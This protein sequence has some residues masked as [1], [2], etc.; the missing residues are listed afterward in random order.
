[1]ELWADLVANRNAVQ[2]ALGYLSE[3]APIVLL[4]TDR[5]GRILSANR[6]AEHLLGP[7]KGKFFVRDVVVDFTGNLTL[8]NLV[9]QENGRRMLNVNTPSGMPDTLQFQMVDCGATMLVLGST[10]MAEHARLQREI[11]LLNQE[12]GN[13]T[14][15]LQKSNAELAK[16]NELK[17]QFLGMAAH[18]LR[19]PAGI[20]MN[21]S[22]LLLDELAEVANPE[23]ME[24]L[25]F[26]LD[27]SR[28]M[29]RLIEDFLD[30]SIIESG[31]LRL[32]CEISSIAQVVSNAVRYLEPRARKKEVSLVVEG[33][34]G[35]P[36]LPIDGPKVAQVVGNLV[37]NAIEH[38]QP[39]GRVWI[40]GAA[41][42]EAVT[43]SVRDEGAGL[44]EEVIERLFHPFSVGGTRKTAGERSVGLG[45]AI[46]RK[47]VEEHRGRIWAESSPG[48]GAIFR[49]TLPLDNSQQGTEG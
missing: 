8:E 14:R 9:N 28:E 38:S 46:A 6:Y 23:Q 20:T 15:A 31:R 4:V 18:D 26:I 30:V 43:V 40:E 44:S 41:T 24:F 45:L 2:A 11:L 29:V 17:N 12:L 25:S 48:L 7:V 16:L 47:I 27:A 33:L 5:P 13:V 32:N 1:M 39:R 21:F 34:G 22:E 10:D 36:Q 49:F 37:G 42:Q 3:D 35:L 19:K